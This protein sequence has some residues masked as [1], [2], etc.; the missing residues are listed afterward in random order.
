MTSPRNPRP[1]TTTDTDPYDVRL[2]PRPADWTEDAACAG[3]DPEVFF[4]EHDP[5]LNAAAKRVC[6]ICPVRLRCLSDA[7]ER[8]EHWGIYGGHNF[9]SGE[10]RMAARRDLA[11]GVA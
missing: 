1:I 5:A 2:F 9:T 4:T 11:R 7:I 6:A 3:Q 8:R 10:N